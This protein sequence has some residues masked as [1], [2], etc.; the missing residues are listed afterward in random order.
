MNINEK[1]NEAYLDLDDVLTPEIK[2]H[3]K[4][5]ME[6]YALLKSKIPTELHSLLLEQDD[7][8]GS[9]MATVAKQYFIRGYIQGAKENQ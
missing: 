1:A 5:T 7:A 2:E 8:I 3:A 4:V 9:Y 6:L